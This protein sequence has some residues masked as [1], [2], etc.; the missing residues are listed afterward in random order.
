MF[1][2]EMLL[3][4]D[5]GTGFHLFSGP[6]SLRYFLFGLGLEVD[7]GFSDS[8]LG[9]SVT[10]LFINLIL[11]LIFTN[12]NIIWTLVI[13]FLF[14]LVLLRIDLVLV[15]IRAAP[16]RKEILLKIQSFLKTLLSVGPLRKRVI[17]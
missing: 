2:G 8:F 7:W 13:A 14:I 15:E 10:F 9:N 17:I 11:L 4:T 6:G 1:Y 5:F 12:I 16:S 3:G